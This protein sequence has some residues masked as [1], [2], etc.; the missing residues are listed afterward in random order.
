MTEIQKL[1]K[2]LSNKERRLTSWKLYHIKDKYW[3]DIPFIPNEDQLKLIRDPHYRHIIPKARQRG[4]TTLICLMWLDSALFNRNWTSW[5]INVD[6]DTADK[7]YA[8]KIRFA[9]DRL[10]KRL[11][12]CYEVKTDKTNEMR[13]S[14]DGISRSAVYVATS[15]RWWTVQFLHISEHA[16]I[17]STYPK[18]AKE[19]NTWTIE[20]VPPNWYAYIE[21]TW[22]W[23]TWD[24]Y[25]RCMQ[26]ELTH[27]KV[28]NEW[29]VMTPEDMKIHFTPRRT[30][31]EYHLDPDVYKVKIPHAEQKYF[32][33]L[34]VDHWI[35]LSLWQKMRYVKKKEKKKE[36]M[37]REYPSILEECFFVS[38]E[39]KYYKNETDKT[40][41]EG[42]LMNIPYDPNKLVHL[43]FDIWW[44][45]WWDF[46]TIRFVQ[47]NKWF[48]DC[49]RYREWS[50]YSMQRVWN[51]ILLSETYSYWRVWLPHDAFNKQQW[52]WDEAADELKNLWF[53]VIKVPKLRIATWIGQ[54]RDI[55]HKCRFD[56]QDAWPWFKRLRAYSKKRSE[57]AWCFIDQPKHDANS[58]WADAFRYFAVD[59]DN[60]M[61]D[62]DVWPTVEYGDFSSLV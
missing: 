29:Y 1:K 7:A 10:P 62:F 21:S 30:A 43:F 38:S 44:A 55:F 46:M 57:T 40:I 4:F 53:N 25:E 24:F 61:P 56:E 59:S 28:V 54:V 39:W 33:M 50:G 16:K 6:K 32:K 37:K 35:E 13:F 36:F 3:K 14:T 11:S 48:F 42:R 15:L 2:L 45:W 12:K 22:D 58:H 5:F 26:A 23:E 34:E 47:Y 31:E 8:D 60:V 17:C 19:L 52:K 51:E 18:K 27:S 20:A 49:F 9:W 41:S